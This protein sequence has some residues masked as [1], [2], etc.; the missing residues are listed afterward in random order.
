MIRVDN[1]TDTLLAIKYENLGL[2]ATVVVDGNTGD[3][4]LVAPWERTAATSSTCPSSAPTRS[5]SAL[6]SALGRTSPCGARTSRTTRSARSKATTTV[7]VTAPVDASGSFAVFGDGP[8]GSDVLNLVGAS[9]RPSKRSPS[10]PDGTNPTDQDV[11]GLGAP[12]DVSGV[13]LITYGADGDDTLNVNPGPG[14]H[15]VRVDDQAGFGADRITS[16]NLPEIHSTGLDRLNIV[17]GGAFEFDR[18]HVRYRFLGR[19]REL[20]I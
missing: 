17:G 5:T 7:N 13:E 11:F 20:H 10:L 19:S 8:G 3:N 9:G 14:D 15:T 2:A 1:S 6:S 18:G 12:I 16:D 4:T